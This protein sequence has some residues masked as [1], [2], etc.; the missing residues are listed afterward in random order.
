MSWKKAAREVRLEKAKPPAGCQSIEQIAEEMG[1]SEDTAKGIIAELVKAGRAE[2]VPGKKL[3]S[4][5]QLVATVY[6]RLL[7]TETAKKKR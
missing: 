4:T 1:C 3:T 2:R 6:Y 7:G 5:D